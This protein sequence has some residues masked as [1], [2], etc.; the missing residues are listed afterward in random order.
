MIAEAEDGG[1][2]R[3]YALLRRTNAHE[4]HRPAGFGSAARAFG[5]PVAAHCGWT[6]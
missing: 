3:G 5:W 1:P 2:A 4:D 6:F